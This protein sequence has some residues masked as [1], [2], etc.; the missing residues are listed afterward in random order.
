MAGIAVVA[1]SLSHQASADSNGC[2]R[3]RAT[4]VIESIGIKRPNEA[5]VKM[6]HNKMSGTIKEKLE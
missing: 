1:D 4:R 5:V 2:A 6:I 3:F